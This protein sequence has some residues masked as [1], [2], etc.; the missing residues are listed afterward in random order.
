MT[1]SRL[2]QEA[3]KER[4]E[5][6]K[7]QN[8]Q[9]QTANSAAGV[10][11]DA[12]YTVGSRL[13]A[14][15]LRERLDRENRSGTIAIREA[16]RP[17]AST[18]TAST[19]VTSR[20]ALETQLA[21]AK[22]RLKANSGYNFGTDA[23][24]DSNAIE[25]SRKR[26][27]AQVEAYNDIKRIE[28]K[29]DD[30]DLAEK[31]GN[32]T[33]TEIADANGF[34][35][36]ANSFSSSD[37]AA[38]ELR[39][40]ERQKENLLKQQTILMNS[41]NAAADDPKLRKIREELNEIDRQ[42]LSLKKEKKTLE[43]YERQALIDSGKYRDASLW[44]VTVNAVKQGYLNSIYGQESYKDMLGRE[45]EKQKYEDILAGEEYRFIP[46]NGFEEAVS[47]AANLLGQQLRQWTDKRSVAGAMT[48][49]GIALATGQAGPQ[50]LIPEEIATVPGAFFAGMQAG[51]YM[52][53]LEIEAGLAYNEMIGNGI[54]PN[55]A[56][57]IALMVG[58]GNAALETLQLDELVKGFR[59]LKNSGATQ[60]AAQRLLQLMIDKGLDIG[61]ETL[62]EVLQEGVTIAGTQA[63]NKLETGEWAYTSDEVLD[64]LGDTAKSSALSFGLMNVPAAGFNSY[65]IVQDQKKQ[66]SAY[67]GA[68]L[69]VYDGSVQDVIETGLTSD[70]S[71][72]SYKQAAA[73]QQKIEKGETVTDAEIGRLYQENIR[74]IEAEERK[75]VSTDNAVMNTS[76]EDAQNQPGTAATTQRTETERA[77]SDE[78]GIFPYKQKNAARSYE[79]PNYGENGMR[80]FMEIAE[81]SDEPMSNVR[82]NFESA[83]QAGLVDTPESALSFANVEQKMAYNAG[84]QDRLLTLSRNKQQGVTATFESGGLLQNELSNDLDTATRDTL[85]KLGKATGAKILFDESLRG[86]QNNGYYK[87]GEI[88]IS[89]DAEDPVMVV[90]K[91][92]LTHHL[93]TAA[94]EAYVAYRD[95]AVRKMNEGQPYGSVTVAEAKQNRYYEL[96]KG[97]VDLTTEGAMDEV[98]AE[99]TEFILGDDEKLRSFVDE[100]SG[101]AETRTWGQKVFD[102]IHAF[103]EKVKG[104][105]GVKNKTIGDEVA[106]KK[107]GVTMQQLEKAEKLWKDA[108]REAVKATKNAAHADGGVN[109]AESVKGNGFQ[110]MFKLKDS[111]ADSV[112]EQ[113]R[114]HISELNAM[115]AVA[116]VTV[117]T[118]FGNTMADA[119]KWIV[120]QLKSTGYQVDRK[121]FG[122]IVF[123]EK[124]LNTSL[125]YINSKAEIAAYAVLPRVLKRGIEIGRHVDHKGRAYGTVTF[126]APVILNGK[127]GNMAAV[128][129]MTNQ[130]GY[131]IHRILMPDGTAYELEST[132]KTEPT[133]ARGVTKTGSLAT[134]ISSADA[135]VSQMGNT[136]KAEAEEMSDRDV[137]YSLRKKDPPKKTGIAYKV[138]L[139]KDGELFPPMVANPGGEGT[140]VGVWLDADIGK[141]AP[142]SKTGRPQVQG[143]G[144]GTNS[145][146]ISL[147]F[148]PGWHLGDIPLAKQFAK[149]N[150]E[151]GKKELF[152]YNFVWAECEYAM[153]VDY[154]EEA[155]SYGYT[156]NGK[157]RHSY[158]G[159][160]K[161]PEDGYYRYRTN[162]N[163][164]TV[165]WIITGAMRVKKV[166]TDAET[167][168]ICREN[169]V[170]PMAREGGPIDLAKFGIKAGDQ[171]KY[172][173]KDKALQSGENGSGDTVINKDVEPVAQFHKNGSA[174]FSLKSTREESKNLIAIHNLTAEKLK[175]TLN[176]GGFPMPSIAIVKSDMGHEEF[177]DISVLFRKDTINPTDRRNKVYGGDAWTPTRPSVGYKVNEKARQR[178]KTKVENLLGGKDL[179]RTYRLMLD[180]TN[181]DDSMNRWNGDFKR[182]YKNNDA[183]KIAFL[184]DKG[185]P[186]KPVMKEHK[187]NGTLSNDALRQIVQEIGASRIIEAQ[188]GETGSVMQFEPVVRKFYNEQME[189]DFAGSRFLEK[190]VVDEL[191]WAKVETILR[192][193]ISFFKAGR[194]KIVD[195]TA[196][197][198]KLKKKFTKK[199]TAE[200]EAWL[201][202]LSD[203]IIEKRGIRNDKDMF[204]PSGNRRSF[205]QLYMSY[206]LDNIVKAM[207]SDENQKGGGV[208]GTG[209]IFGASA[210]E[211]SSITEVKEDSGR[212][213]K[214]DEETHKTAHD[215]FVDRLQDITSRMIKPGDDSFG[216][217]LDAGDAAVDALLKGKTVNGILRELKTWRRFN[218][219]QQIAEDIYNLSQDIANAPTAY[220]EAKPRRAVGFDEVAAVVMPRAGNAELKS[221]LEARG[222]QVLTYN[223]NKDGDRLKKINSVKDIRFSMKDQ[224]D[225]LR[226]N[227]K[228]KAVNQALRDQFK[229]TKFAKVDRKALDSF[230]KKLLRD[231]RSG[232]DIDDTR[233]DLDDL[234]TYIA[235]GEDGE[236]ATWEA[237]YRKAFDAAMN[238]LQNVSVV[239]DDLYQEYKELRDRLRTTGITL[240]RQYT[241]SLVGYDSISEFRKKY[242]GRIKLVKDGLPVDV[243]YEELASDYPGLFDAYEYTNP[244]DQLLNIAEV[245]DS[246]QPYEENPYSYNMRESASWLANDI[247]E[248]F[249]ELPQAKPTFADKAERKL[250]ETKIKDQKKLDKLREQ[251]NVRIAEIIAENREKVK[252]VQEKERQKRAEAVAETKEHYA[253]KEARMS[254]NRKASVLR[255]RITKHAADLSQKLLRPSDKQ[256]IP[257][258]LRGTVAALLESIN[259]ESQYTIDPVTGKRQ[260]NGGGEPVKR[261]QLFQ[262]LKKQYMRI[263]QES[264]MVVDPALLGDEE[265]QGWFEQVIALGETRVADMNL[266]ELNILW[267][268]MRSV[269]HSITTANKVLSKAKFQ[270]TTEWANA[271]QEETAT[272]RAMKGR[273]LEE[274]R[275]DLENPYTFFS[276]Y[277]EA[278]HAIYRMLRNAQDHQQTMTTA[279]QAEVEKIVYPKTVR[280]LEKETHEFTTER[281]EKL[282]LTTA[283]IMEIHELM[284]R[285]QARDHLTKGGIVQPEIKSAKIKRGTD[286]VLLTL[287]DLSSIVGTLTDEQVQIADALQKLTSTMLAAYGN[288]ASMKAYGYKKFTGTDYWP[289]KS[290]REGVH[291]NIEKGN[292]NTR[293]IKNIGLA[294]S[295]IPHANNPLDIGGVFRT[296]STHA[297]DMIDYAAWLCPMEDANRLYN[298]EF[299][300]IDGS[301][302]GKTMKGL[303]DRVGG[304]GAQQYWFRLMED[305]QNGI[306]PASDTWYGKA[307]D[308]I[309][310]NVKGAAVGAN[311]RVVIQQPTAIVRAAAVLSPADMAK[312][313]VSGGGWKAAMEHSAIAQ[314]KDMGG[315]DIGSPMQ[316]SEILF[317]TRTG[318]RK[319]NDKL[320][321]PAGAA[322]AVTWGRIWNA[323]EWA[324][325]RKQPSLKAGSEDFYAVVDEI[326]TEVIDQ[327]QV[328]DGVLQRAQVMRSGN[329]VVKQ[330]TAFMGEPTMS[331]NMVLRAYDEWRGQ[332]DK[333]KRSA[334]LKK[335]SKTIIV[336]VATNAVNALAQSL[337]DAERDDDDEKKYWERVWAA[338]T[339]L[340][341]EEESAW[342]KATAAVLNGNLG[343]GL[344]LL[345]YMPGTKDIISI[346]SGYDV[347]RMDADVMADIIK[348]GK[349]FAES[350]GGSGKKTPAAAL[351]EFAHNIARACGISATNI[352]RDAWGIYRSIAIETDNIGLLYEITKAE[353][354]IGFE[355]NSGQFIDLLYRAYTSDKTAYEKIYADMVE[356][357]I[358]PE[359]IKNG[360]ETRMK[361]DQGVKKVEDLA[362]RYLPPEQKNRYDRSISSMDKSSVWR[363]ATDAQRGEIEADLHDLITESD[364]GKALQEKIDEGAAW[365]VDESEY[366]L[367]KLALDM[368]DQPN[369]SGEYGGTPTNEEKA[370]AIAK[371]DGLRDSEIAY[372]WD[373]E[374][375]YDAFAS[376]IDMR[377]Y[378]EYV[379]D[380]GGVSIEKIISAKEAGIEEDTYFDFLDMLNEYDQPTE[381]GKYG[382]FT[383]AK[384]AAAVAAMPGLTNEERAYLWQSVNKSWKPDKNPW[385]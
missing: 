13:Q 27:Q 141:Q 54:S 380:G 197:S 107:Y 229:T 324:V 41:R 247:M 113:L 268:V 235:N 340:S 342:E 325:K 149:L 252:R 323:C 70:P 224:N 336:L 305:I 83:Y 329:A 182:A 159:L 84:Q 333:A 261:T 369:K 208:L 321:A 16:V 303:L 95:Y 368:V 191:S 304:N 194:K 237:A 72:K 226:E 173:P 361:K 106:M 109:A 65:N 273:K 34:M 210:K 176:L 104:A 153:D 145:G 378:V 308:K 249:F 19:N 164:D 382:S 326:F 87:N 4:E 172:S 216:S 196:T 18:A 148:R 10:P 218:A 240:D 222:V 201:D 85:H 214:E 193:S 110:T 167:D 290:A 209:N 50:A 2:R 143:G 1:L 200:Y 328:V 56:Q 88:H 53:N 221:Q 79:D 296:F 310:G 75:A 92:E 117:P 38:S 371:L 49:A 154:Q 189:K 187:Y 211:Y 337:I 206:N 257:E 236:G 114:A 44:D 306:K 89:P 275:M 295:V 131:K 105:L 31:W 24:Y 320:S 74:T 262:D 349:T 282:T 121:G 215:A 127:R 204:T 118:S 377:S 353:Y 385:K 217:T 96:S 343:S 244:A 185:I 8:A 67:G 132:K 43:E 162:P 152:P 171:V 281:G 267:N 243:A 150:K 135:S 6:Q 9:R 205:E 357:G 183:L 345:T 151:T 372:L 60:S 346:F 45:N 97:E 51:S 58:G 129:K 199:L 86:G 260:K 202:E 46:G 322:D 318:L 66:D 30:L 175:E 230:A 78:G 140:P 136:V 334:A 266:E 277:G 147:A 99:F 124:R 376:G 170:E 71:T 77:V 112:K 331:L 228:L 363:S 100:I 355:S 231:Y 35:D 307:V 270:K 301:R 130:N 26:T 258:D 375:G 62:Q 339:G 359:K 300:G 297:A 242:F 137:K 39:A 294:K 158:A 64:R 271:I 157:F 341:G 3:Q 338:F 364:A 12:D 73:L 256:H 5:A 17:P 93:Q 139:A 111:E 63:A 161:L 195:D 156:E 47:G 23:M 280:N 283:H 122:T 264:S 52:S 168:A 354:N 119:R 312:G 21:E 289:I 348:S 144:K 379:G 220:F 180:D 350:I 233:T 91:H 366:L 335:I 362:D 15:A 48:G 125:N 219:T 33:Y 351:K 319:F 246:L 356:S 293:S 32:K 133:P 302:T 327:T 203:G 250:T 42:A 80:T 373:T 29:L 274:I 287:D 286:S 181:V 61:N 160:P 57:K 311:I 177:G 284:K 165:P 163:P 330:A 128:V 315:F 116:N 255:K 316:M 146:K 155:M 332:T 276:H 186:F 178:I 134:P 28:K 142:P 234:Y 272:R 126:A 269:E 169:G 365:G 94:P 251:K 263:S 184:K 123:D 223:A 352:I 232:A 374:D 198:D 253:A 103:I 25:S 347:T 291:S 239:N 188:R 344:N 254:E 101:T 22:A 370:A 36:E 76:T 309:V 192:D 179:M 59:I 69:E 367:Y 238:I 120:N 314:R 115:D 384:A 227:A 225:L 381:S 278:G 40:L 248:R 245:L 190:M 55:V 207:A 213:I 298:Y 82:M 383:Q 288:E 68:I 166:L 313:L 241:D 37:M 90:V 279:L 102:A 360:M 174:Q 7:K 259:L 358:D 138:F 265:T 81:T 108:V 20:K 14:E 285:E 292:T 11:A 299:R 212:L 317:D 98:A